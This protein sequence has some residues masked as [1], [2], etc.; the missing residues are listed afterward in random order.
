MR[1]GY[2]EV[3]C[4]GGGQVSSRAGMES[5]EAEVPPHHGGSVTAP[6]LLPH[7]NQALVTALP[8]VLLLSQPGPTPDFYQA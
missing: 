7:L 1:L 3:T 2:Y 5:Q 4:S 6:I 8:V